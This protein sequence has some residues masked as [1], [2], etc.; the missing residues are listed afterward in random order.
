MST[1]DNIEEVKKYL[2]LLF[3]QANGRPEELTLIKVP[4][5]FE[6]HPSLG[7]FGYGLYFKGDL[8]PTW[9]N[10]KCDGLNNEPCQNIGCHNI[11]DVKRQKWRMS[12][13]SHFDQF[14]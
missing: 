14:M 7:R 2:D 9:E 12:C 8:M 5:K 13:V 11:W 10:L 4:P 1:D 3:V 6:D